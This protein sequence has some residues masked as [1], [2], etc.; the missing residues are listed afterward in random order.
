VIWVR[1]E[2]EYFWKWGWTAR[3]KRLS[4]SRNDELADDLGFSLADIQEARQVRAIADMAR[5]LPLSE[6]VKAKLDKL[7]PNG[8]AQ[9]AAR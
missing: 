7:Q 5:A 2:R 9:G 3:I 1:R 6:E 4:H 8:S